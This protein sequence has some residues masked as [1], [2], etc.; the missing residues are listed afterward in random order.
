MEKLTAKLDEIELKEAE[1]EAA[2]IEKEVNE[3]KMLHL[4]VTLETGLN[5]YEDV[6]LPSSFL[7]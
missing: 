4:R 3:S 2:R 6:S 7:R 5:L 1:R